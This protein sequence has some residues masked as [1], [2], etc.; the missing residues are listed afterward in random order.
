MNVGA[1]ERYIHGSPFA[2]VEKEDGGAEP[3]GPRLATAMFGK[4]PK[5]TQRLLLFYFVCPDE[6]FDAFKSLF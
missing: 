1:R 3:A 5:A 2:Y 6:V 4:A